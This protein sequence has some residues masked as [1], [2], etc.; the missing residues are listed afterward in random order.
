MIANRHLEQNDDEYYFIDGFFL[1][2][3]K[4][5]QRMEKDKKWNV[6]CYY[7]DNLIRLSLRIREKTF[8]YEFANEFRLIKRNGSIRENEYGILLIDLKDIPIRN[9]ANWQKNSRIEKCG[10]E[11]LY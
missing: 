2:K 1:T 11:P 3:R 5:F 4:L 9:E 6:G 8:W 10:F 7:W